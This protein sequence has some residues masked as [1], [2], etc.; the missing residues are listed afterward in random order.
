MGNG[1]DQCFVRSTFEPFS[2]CPHSERSYHHS[3]FSFWQ[4]PLSRSS[5]VASDKQV[6]IPIKA[7][8]KWLRIRSCTFVMYYTSSHFISALA[9]KEM[10]ARTLNYWNGVSQDKENGK[11]ALL[12]YSLSIDIHRLFLY[13][14]QNSPRKRQSQVMTLSW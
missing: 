14:V 2:P 5:S 11:N 10:Q 1:A 7:N 9:H 4:S 8:P 3:V 12:N 13:V 6:L